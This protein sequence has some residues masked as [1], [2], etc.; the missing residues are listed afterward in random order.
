VKPRETIV[1][2][3]EFEAVY[4]VAPPMTQLV[5]LLAR[6]AGLRHAAILQFSASCCNFENRTIMGRTKGGASYNVPMTQRLYERLLFACAGTRDSKVSLLAQYN[7]RASRNPAYNTISS[8]LFKA[9]QAAGVT[10][11]WGLHDLRR[12]AA[13]A[14]YERTRDIRK[15]QR[16]LSHSSPMQTWWYIG[17]VGIELTHEEIEVVSCHPRPEP[18]EPPNNELEANAPT[19]SAEKRIA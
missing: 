9:K 1:P 18:E 13:R 12:T 17:N 15:V 11:A 7:R 2:D 4:R 10:S 14:L 16:F 8:G 3:V 6:E 5:M 19:P